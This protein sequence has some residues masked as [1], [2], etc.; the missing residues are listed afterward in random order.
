MNGFGTGCFVC[1]YTWVHICYLGGKGR[2]DWKR[3]GGGEDAKKRRNRG[4]ACRTERREEK[5][6]ERKRESLDRD[7][8]GWHPSVPS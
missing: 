4:L 8:E 5:R 3:E 7:T 2:L 6:Q 1:P